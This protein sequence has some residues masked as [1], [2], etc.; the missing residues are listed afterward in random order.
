M[1][2]LKNLK[3][4]TNNLDYI[5][6]EIEKENENNYTISNNVIHQYGIYLCALILGYIIIHI[7]IKKL[8]WFY[9]E[10]TNKEIMNSQRTR[11]QDRIV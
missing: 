11:G 1:P 5:V 10:E 3:K 6:T 9:V 4:S 2:N 8:V 7:M